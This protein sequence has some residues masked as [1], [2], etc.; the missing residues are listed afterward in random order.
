LT[1]LPLWRSLDP[2]PILEARADRDKAKAV[3][4]RR[5]KSRRKG[6][7]GDPGDGQDDGKLGSIIN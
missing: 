3:A 6:G 2:L 5:K 4:K 7:A 1:S